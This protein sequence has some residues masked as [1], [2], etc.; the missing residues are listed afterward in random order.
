MPI[1]HLI[2]SIDNFM[3]RSIFTRFVVLF[4]VVVESSISRPHQLRQ[5]FKSFFVSKVEAYL[6]SS[7]I[8][9]NG[10]FSFLMCFREARFRRILNQYVP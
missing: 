6:E 4:S 3:N 2:E 9:D 1:V 8:M 10:A 7:S 5:P